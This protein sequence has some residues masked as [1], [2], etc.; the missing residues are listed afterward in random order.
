MLR[1]EAKE[2]IRAKGGDVSE[3]VS[4]KTNYVVAG[5]NPGSK[6]KKAEQLGVS[7]LTEADF[8]KLLGRN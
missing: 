7:V 1:D 5:D 4:V 6:L 2:K 8:L 3:S